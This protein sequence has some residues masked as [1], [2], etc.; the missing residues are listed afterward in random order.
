M[1]HNKIE[2]CQIKTINKEII[3]NTKKMLPN[4]NTI[5]KVADFFKILADN[6]RIKI[7]CSLFIN[8]MCV[9]DLSDTLNM[10][11][12]AVSHQLK[13]LK[14]ANVIKNRK[15][16]KSAYY[17]LCDEHVRQTLNQV[18]KHIEEC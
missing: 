8:E 13:T 1:Q 11:Q 6:T 16:G 17:S 2:I 18:I 12:S 15:E 14:S 5:Y 4:E 7:L 10:D 9:C 3:E